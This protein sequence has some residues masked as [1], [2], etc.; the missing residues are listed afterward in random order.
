MSF[1]PNCPLAA[2]QSRFRASPRPCRTQALPQGCR[3]PRHWLSSRRRSTSTG[4]FSSAAGWLAAR[5]SLPAGTFF[6]LSTRLRAQ[7]AAAHNQ[8]AAPHLQPAP[9]NACRR[10]WPERA[11]PAV[12]C[13]APAVPVRHGRPGRAPGARPRCGRRRSSRNGRS[14]PDPAAGAAAGRQDAA[15]ADCS[16]RVPQVHGRPRHWQG[17]RD[18]QEPAAVHRRHD[19]G[20]QQAGSGRE[21][22]GPRATRRKAWVLRFSAGR[23]LPAACCCPLG[24]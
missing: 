9:A 4:S 3:E 16:G 12:R 14:R 24:E 18:D 22:Q 1:W 5:P 20:G 11:A 6:A 13:A 21:A 10:V 17:R 8:R 7:P 2:R 19:P 23:L 15:Q